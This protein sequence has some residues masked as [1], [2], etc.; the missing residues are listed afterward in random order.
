MLTYPPSLQ[1][2]TAMPTFHFVRGGDL[3]GMFTGADEAKLKENLIK[4]AKKE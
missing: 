1:Q 3:V 4:L 2:V